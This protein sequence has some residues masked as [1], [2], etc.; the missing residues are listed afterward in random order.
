MV[1]VIRACW[2]E[3]PDLR[4]KA[5]AVVDKLR[6]IHDSGG[7]ASVDAASTRPPML[8]LALPPHPLSWTPSAAGILPAPNRL[9]PCSCLPVLCRRAE[10]AVLL[11]THAGAF[12]R[13]LRHHVSPVSVSSQQNPEARRLLAP[14]AAGRSCKIL[15]NFTLDILSMY[16]MLQ[17]LPWPAHAQ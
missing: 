3:A 2:Q 14:H 6:E 12:L 16:R 13:V 1:R 15:V 7:C 11:S 17:E 8:L 9:L 4:P 5:C 10:G